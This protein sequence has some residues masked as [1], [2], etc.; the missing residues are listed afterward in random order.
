MSHEK[1]TTGYLWCIGDDFTQ[2][3][4]GIIRNHYEDPL[5]NNQYSMER[6]AGIFFGSSSDGDNTD[7]SED[8]TLGNLQASFLFKHTVFL[9]RAATP[10]SVFL[11]PALKQVMFI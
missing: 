4:I 2:L 11:G 8:L 1:K 10:I 3:Y 9:S 6:K 7:S 5:L